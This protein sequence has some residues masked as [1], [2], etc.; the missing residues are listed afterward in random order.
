MGLVRLGR[1]LKLS[2]TSLSEVNRAI[3]LSQK[4]NWFTVND[5]HID[6][7]V[8]VIHTLFRNIKQFFL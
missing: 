5:I 7:L 8:N 3:K 2:G 1:E 6:H 4:K